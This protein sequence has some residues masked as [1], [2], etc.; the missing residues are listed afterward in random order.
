MLKAILGLKQLQKSLSLPSL[1]NRNHLSSYSINANQLFKEKLEKFKSEQI[2]EPENSLEL[3][4]ANVL[5][6]KKLREVRGENLEKI[7]LTD[8]EAKEIEEKIDCRLSR[9]PTQYIIKQW[10]FRD[11][12]LKMSIPV[13]IP[14]PETE[15]LV[16]LIAQ[17]LDKKEDYK[18]LEVGCG[19]GAISLSILNELPCIKQVIAIDQSKAACELT[20]ENAKNLKLSDRL[21]VFKHKLESSKLPEKITSI[22]DKFDI[23]ISNPPYVPSKDILKLDPEIYLYEDIRALDGGKEGL[24]VIN[25]IIELSANYL[26]SGG[27]LWMEVD[28][29]HPEIIAKIVENNFEKWNLKF[30]AS[31]KDIF[32]KE[33]FV[34]IEKV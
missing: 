24:D 7:E 18:I 23:I 15:E 6:K 16:E 5:K 9:M 4:F 11:L 26:K 19:T 14:R 1:I 31:Y 22:A 28:H 25:N 32:K 17:Q 21:R 12:E 33:R 10:E 27:N 34:E 30:I 20:L 29:R 13:F 3:I 8:E 2:S